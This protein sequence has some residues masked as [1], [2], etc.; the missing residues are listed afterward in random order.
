MQTINIVW[1][2]KD[3]RLNDHAALHAAQQANIPFLIVYLFEPEVMQRADV[4]LRHSQ[5]IY[6]SLL[7]LKLN[8]GA[9]SHL[10]HILYGERKAIFQEI[11]QQ[12]HVDTIFSYQESGTESTWNLDKEIG[13]LFMQT[14]VNWKEFQ[15]DAIQRGIKNRKG[16]D[17]HWYTVMHKDVQ[18]YE[19][20]AIQLINFEHSFFLPSEFKADLETYPSL[21][22]PA[23]ER[24][25]WKYLKDFMDGRCKGYSRYISKPSESRTSCSRLSVYITYGNISVRQ[26]YQYVKQHPNF[27]KYKFPIK[28]FLSRL[29]WQNHFI[30]KFEVQCDYEYRFLNPAYEEMSYKHT[31]KWIL[32]WAEGKTGVPMI[33]ASMRCLKATGWINF[34]MRAM[35][36]SFLTHHLDQ[37]WRNGAFILANYFLDFEPGI[38][39]PQVQMQAGTTGVHTLRIYNPIKQGKEHD[40]KGIFVRKWIPELQNVPDNYIHEPWQ[41]TEME[42]LMLNFDL[43]RDYYAPIVNVEQVAGEAREKLWAFKKRPKV[44]KYKGSILEKHTRKK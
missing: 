33:D 19:P 41:M 14:G 30:Q 34:R 9:Q 16:W 18:L 6:H 25:A 43:K 15:R 36:V 3:I 23:G 32:A 10:L 27:N 12:F 13:A 5:F 20:K 11:F 29:K 28:S 2:K 24:M 22:Q 7:D 8:L 31:P 35:L 17:K 21:Y 40:P 42:M 26:V 1:M 38:H 4:S 37:D 44:N 39:Y